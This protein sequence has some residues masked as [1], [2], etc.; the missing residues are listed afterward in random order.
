MNKY[1]KQFLLDLLQAVG[2]LLFSAIR[3]SIG[4]AAVCVTI[5]FVLV[6]HYI[7][8]GELK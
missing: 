2:V 7:E 5:G 4:F 1:Q 3:P 8:L 6:W